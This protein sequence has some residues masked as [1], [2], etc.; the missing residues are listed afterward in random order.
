MLRICDAPYSAHLIS[1]VS[2]LIVNLLFGS[3]SASTQISAVNLSE[4]AVVRFVLNPVVISLSLLM[5]M[6]SYSTLIRGHFS[7]V[8][9]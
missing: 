8:V 6:L 3:H 4:S 5:A 2:D 9:R 7:V 1:V